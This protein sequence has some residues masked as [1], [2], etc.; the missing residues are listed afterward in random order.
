MVMPSTELGKRLA[1]AM[2]NAGKTQTALAKEIGVSQ[3]TVGYLLSGRNKTTSPE[4]MQKLSQVLNVSI[5]WLN[6]QEGGMDIILLQG[7]EKIPYY[8]NEPCWNEQFSRYDFIKDNTRRRAVFSREFFKENNTTADDCKIFEVVTD[9]MAPVLQKGDFVLIDCLDRY[10]LQQQKQ[11]IYAVVTRNFLEFFK[12]IPTMDY[13]ML[14]PANP[15][16]P[17][18]EFSYESFK[19]DFFVVGKVIYKF[20]KSGLNC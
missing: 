17:G 1:I 20:G 5:S 8:H 7:Y 15:A 16:F 9:V 13:V 19:K 11:N 14:S 10:P 6:G 18:K 12:I 4:I 3:A 2:K